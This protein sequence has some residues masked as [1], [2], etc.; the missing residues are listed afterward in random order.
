MCSDHN[1]VRI[2]DSLA[3][4]RAMVIDDFIGNSFGDCG[5]WFRVWDCGIGGLPAH[6]LII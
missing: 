5:G 6:I 1:G 2:L 3:D 4:I